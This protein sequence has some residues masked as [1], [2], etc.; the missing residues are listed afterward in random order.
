MI[1]GRL[2]AYAF[3]QGIAQ[4]DRAA[5]LFKKVAEGLIG[6]IL[7]PLAGIKRQL[8]QRVP[9]RG[10]KLD[11]PADG[12][13]LHGAADCFFI[14]AKSAIMGAHASLSRPAGIPIFAVQRSRHGDAWNL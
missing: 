12:C 4:R 2:H 6:K 8:I 11:A 3:S 10:I 13:V 5:M 7:Q 1:I 9:A 14:A